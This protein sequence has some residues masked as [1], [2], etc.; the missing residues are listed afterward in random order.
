MSN[1]QEPLDAIREALQSPDVRI[2]LPHTFTHGRGVQVYVKSRKIGPIILR[3][4]DQ[5][6]AD[7][8]TMIGNL[9]ES[10]VSA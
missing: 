10:E 7:L 6:L 3:S 5:S 9:A 2:A 4:G 1:T 8:L